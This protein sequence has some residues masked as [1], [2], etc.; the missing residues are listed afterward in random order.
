M[1]TTYETMHD[2]STNTI[3]TPPRWVCVQCGRRLPTH[4]NVWAW[5]YERRD[6]SG[7]NSGYYCD[8]CA[9]A[10]ESGIDY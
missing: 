2:E 9:D 1:I 4:G 6:M 3:P 7:N 10:R 5:R 8:N